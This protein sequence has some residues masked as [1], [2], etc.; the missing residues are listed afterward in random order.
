MHKQLYNKLLQR[1][2]REQAGFGPRCSSVHYINTLRVIVEQ[3]VEWGTPLYF[4][5]IGFEK[6]FDTLK[7]KSGNRALYVV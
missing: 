6:A 7:Q 2:R 5:Y 4:C 1:L 3:S